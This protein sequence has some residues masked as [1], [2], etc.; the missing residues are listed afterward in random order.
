MF[1]MVCLPIYREG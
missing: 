1:E